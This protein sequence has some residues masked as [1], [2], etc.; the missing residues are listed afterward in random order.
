M[1]AGAG[2]ERVGRLDA[3]V[4]I[5]LGLAQGEES[6]EEAE[7]DHLGQRGAGD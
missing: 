5:L 4:S 3:H 6:E 1:V 7:T 2:S